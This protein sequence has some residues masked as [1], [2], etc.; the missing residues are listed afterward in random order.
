VSGEPAGL[1]QTRWTALWTRLGA[2]GAGTGTFDLLAAAYREPARAYHTA[3]HINDCLRELDHHRELA[4]RP[5]E[6]EAAIW[7]HDAVYVPGASDNEARS[8]K[9]AIAELTSAGILSAVAH[10]IGELILATRH[11]EVPSV[12]DAQ[13]LCDI[14]LA[15]LGRDLPAFDAYQQQI[16][17]EYAWVPAALYRKG[18]AKVLQDFLSR[19]SIYQTPAFHA[20]Y[21]AAARQNLTRA[22]TSLSG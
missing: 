17:Q 3:A 11:S 14:D 16:R 7:F 21:E 5:D 19:H 22:L 20:R 8:A 1:D 2:A 4:A 12:P 9:L 6:V 13:L 10:R 15:I 18:R